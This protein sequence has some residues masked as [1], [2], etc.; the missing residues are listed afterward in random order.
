M[1]RIAY[2]YSR[3]SS[4]QQA[5][6]DSIRRQ[7]ALARAWCQR[8]GAALDTNATYEDRGTSAFRGKHR[9]SGLLRR[10]LDDVESGHIPR[11]SVL[12]IENMDR[13]SREKPV[14]GVNVLT[15][16]LIAGVRVVQ[17]APD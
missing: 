1:P 4:P 10:F 15:G 13:L 9:E 2:S 11:D 6:G 14:V 16:I 5:D 17:L 8:N 12:L 3:Y 7:T